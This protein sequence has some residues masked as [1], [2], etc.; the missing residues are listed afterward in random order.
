VTDS[1]VLSAEETRT[2]E[3]LLAQA[4]GTPV[5]VRAAEAI[6]ERSHIV[7]LRLADERTVVLKRRRT[8]NDGDRARD[9][10]T[11]LAALDLLNGMEIAVAPRLFGADAAAGI[12]LM[13]DLGPG[14]SLAHSL[15]AGPSDRAEA[16][17]V[18]YARALAAMHSWSI[19]LVTVS[20]LPA[21]ALGEPEWMGV[22]ASRKE[23]F[24]AVMAGLGL[25]ADGAGDDID[26][27][28]SLLRGTPATGFVHSDPCPDN[29][30]I[31][32][33]N[34][35]IFDF[36]TSGWGPVA[37]DAAY[38]LAPFPSCW[39]FA[40]LPPAA[41]APAL[42]AYREEIAQAGIDL[43][44]DWD[45]VMTAALGSWIVARGEALG[46]A[47]DQDED[48]G[49]T[50]MRPRLLRWL[51][52]FTEAADRSGALPRLRALAA[53]ADERLSAR[54][55]EAVVPGYPALADPGAPV[56][57]YPDGW[58][59]AGGLLTYRVQPLKA[60]PQVRESVIDLHSREAIHLAAIFKLFHEVEQRPFAARPQFLAEPVRAV[61]AELGDQGAERAEFAGVRPDP[62]GLSPLRLTR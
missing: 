60:G 2:A 54:W 1:P 36:E 62:R 56:A 30:H 31:V 55:P 21:P 32:D 44:H 35:R 15:L 4:W 39:C 37:L 50:T 45:A 49:T 23:S 46:E 53:A 41:A 38:L 8:E 34:C 47:L 51:R 13:E 18:S 42:H 3:S 19:G 57:R 26:S 16:D 52:S 27:L 59:I 61:R 14:S 17:L 29:T 6:W 25:D 11:E 43:G 40:S 20:G 22:I 10:D 33:G 58:E 7:R 48:W 5:S 28:V 24:L 9:F 12:L